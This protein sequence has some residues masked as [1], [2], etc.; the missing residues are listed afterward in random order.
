MDYCFKKR[1]NPNDAYCWNRAEEAWWVLRV[2]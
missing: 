1:W 2:F